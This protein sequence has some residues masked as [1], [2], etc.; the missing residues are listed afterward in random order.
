[1]NAQTGTREQIKAAIGRELR[2]PA[3]LLNDSATTASLGLDSLG[4]AQA[5]V[6]VEEALAGEVDT[7]RFSEQLTPDMTLGQLVEVVEAS[8]V[9][10]PDPAGSAAA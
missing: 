3:E 5:V 1:M 8:L 10:A 9:R 7:A 2:L 6:A 4:L